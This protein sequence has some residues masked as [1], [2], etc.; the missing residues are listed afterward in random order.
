MLWSSAA[1]H[2]SADPAPPYGCYDSVEGLRHHAVPPCWP[3]RRCRAPARHAL[4]VAPATMALRNCF[5]P[6]RPAS[7]EFFGTALKPLENAPCRLANPTLG[8]P[9]AG[10]RLAARWAP[11]RSEEHTSELQSLMRT[12]Y[13]A[14]C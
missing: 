13:A 3:R 2:V 6:P 7:K 12:S 4:P 1:S 8:R 5:P 9:R 14:S 11:A 10:S